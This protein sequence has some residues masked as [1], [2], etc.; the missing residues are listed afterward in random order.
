MDCRKVKER[1]LEYLEGGLPLRERREI[2][3]HLRVC[4]ECNREIESLKRLFSILDREDIPE[5]EEEFWRRLPERVYIQLNRSQRL[6]RIIIAIAASVVIVIGGLLLFKYTHKEKVTYPISESISPIDTLSD[7]IVMAKN[8]EEIERIVF[9]EI[10][11]KDLSVLESEEI[12]E[13]D[14]DELIDELSNEEKLLLCE[15]L[16]KLRKGGR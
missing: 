7:L 11:P 12:E 3:E 2:R 13:S 8:R 16:E 9:K 14:I 6:H 1:L 5:P 15:E 4:K 10:A